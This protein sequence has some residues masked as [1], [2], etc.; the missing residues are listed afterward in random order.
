MARP[1][2]KVLSLTDRAAERMAEIMA[3][4]DENYIGV[5]IGV[6]NG[7]CA[8]MEYTMDYATE[9]AP[10]DEVVED[11]GITGQRRR[12]GQRARIVGRHVQGRTGHKLSHDPGD[13]HPLPGLSRYGGPANQGLEQ[14]LRETRNH[15]AQGRSRDINLG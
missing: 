5:K 1:K 12:L 15:V 3:Q 7:G 14:P 4:A 9:A 11:N 13:K 6:K 8:G 2:P 10:L